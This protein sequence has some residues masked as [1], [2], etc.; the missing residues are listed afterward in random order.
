MTES[1]HTYSIEVGLTQEILEF[2]EFFRGS[3]DVYN[4]LDLLLV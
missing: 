3:V 4:H 2:C 1:K